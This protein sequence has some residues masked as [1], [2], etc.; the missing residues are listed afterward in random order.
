M[1]CGDIAQCYSGDF[2]DNCPGFDVTGTIG[3]TLNSDCTFS[4]I[5][6]YGV[7]TTGKITDRLG[8]QFSGTGTTDSK[9][10]G[11]F[12]ISCTTFGSYVSCSYNYDKG[13]AGSLPS[14]S[15]IQCMPD[16]K[17]LTWTLVGDW[18]FFYTQ[19]G[20]F[21]TLQDQ[22]YEHPNY[23]GRYVTNGTLTEYSGP[24][25]IFPFTSS[26]YAFYDPVNNYYRVVEP[27]P[28]NSS[29]IDFSTIY[30]FNYISKDEVYG[31]R[32]YY[33]DNEYT[34]CYDFPGQKW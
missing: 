28:P 32:C 15:P 18:R 4:T 13:G 7:K 5:S 29:L 17:Y 16:N 21:I 14:I 9:G 25:G 30:T 12:D 8:S 10:C 2:T 23:P 31:T 22:I 33:E 27:P 24:G 11:A 19:S 34:G 6:T 20:E 26:V 3:F 1:S